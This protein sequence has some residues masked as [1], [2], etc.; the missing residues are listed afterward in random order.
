MLRDDVLY[1]RIYLITLYFK[2][3]P[4]KFYIMNRFVDHIFRA[5][6]A[7]MTLCGLVSFTCL[8]ASASSPA[9]GPGDIIP[10]PAEYEVSSGIFSL[11]GEKTF[12]LTGDK[13][14]GTD[15]RAAVAEALKSFSSGMEESDNSRSADIVVVVDGKKFM[16]KTTLEHASL[17]NAALLGDAYRLEVTPDRITV[18]AADAAGAFYA[19]QS[20]VQMAG[21]DGSSDIQCCV[22]DDVPRFEYRGL[23]FDVSRHFR[24]KEFLMKQMDA[25][26]MLKLNRMHL[27]LTDGAGWRIEIDGYPRLTD[28]A[29]WRPYRKW[30]DWWVSDR[31][32]CEKD[33]PGAYGGYYTRED[34]EEILAYAAQRHIEVI[35]EIEMPGHS[36][37]V[38]AAYPE[39]SCSGKQYGSGDF[40]PGKEATFTFL[41]DVLSEI[42]ELFPSEYIHIGGDEASKSSWKTCPDCCRRMQEEGL[43]DVDELQS[44]LIHR[45][46]EFVNSKGR[47][48]IGWDEI[49]QGGLAPN[50]TVMSWRG[51]EGGIA[52]MKSGHDV[53]MTPGAFCYLDYTQDAPFKEPV[54]IG[55]Y[56]PLSKTYSYEPAEP[57]LT[58]AE[59][60]HLLGVQGNLWAEYI[61]DDSHAEYMY[62]P[63]AF[64]IAEI[65]W[66]RPE[67]KDYEDFHRRALSLSEHLAG[68]GY[69]TFDLKTEYGDR[70]E[71]LAPL[72]HLAVGCDVDY[73]SPINS[74]YPASGETS[75]VD[76]ILGG[77]TYGDKKWQGFLTDFDVTVDLG[78]VQP[79]HYIGATFMQVASAWVYLPEKVDIY[80]SE[81]GSDFR[82][83]GSVWRDLSSK[84]DGL[85]FKQYG[86]I[87]NESARYVRIHA[88]NSGIEGAWL[89]T[90]EIVVN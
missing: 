54:S 48:I 33:V 29:A 13:T 76:G 53:I 16:K 85:F 77:W 73:S 6:L 24:S 3:F 83:A 8:T 23:H 10:V 20:L 4:D 30:S 36:E 1:C 63:R 88:D 59:L 72:R 39:L 84:A 5:S 79:V 60:S 15:D 12:F 41:E 43:E 34:I 14:F 49:L 25:M 28:F 75:L 38:I 51:T 82:L 71:S 64:A 21:P 52:A 56:I 40:C 55:G 80:V 68:L 89:F 46:E 70:K 32:Y 66:S 7:S 87:C 22:I 9:Y 35:P 42:M 37:E 2:P 74:Q 11:A 45:I 57:G 18:Y 67:D 27:H 81:D 62:Y 44:Y 90:D 26:A 31:H 19:L 50:A 61:P 78:S 86:I 47:K 58:E 69:T 17:D 65:G